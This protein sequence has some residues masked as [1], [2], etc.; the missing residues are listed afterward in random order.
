MAIFLQSDSLTG[1]YGLSQGPYLGER[2]AQS[3]APIPLIHRWRNGATTADILAQGL[4]DPL[5]RTGDLFLYLAGTNDALSC[6]PAADIYRRSA[7]YIERIAFLGSEVLWLIPPLLEVGATQDPSRST[8]ANAILGTYRRLIEASGVS[9]YAL[10]PLP[11]FKE[12]MPPEKRHYTTD[13]VHFTQ[14]FHRFFA[15]DVRDHLLGCLN[16]NPRG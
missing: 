5:P 12:S 13:G 10:D 4:A 16:C 14:D 1:P 7:L 11:H 2:L 6:V 3:L 9:C 8:Q 15:D